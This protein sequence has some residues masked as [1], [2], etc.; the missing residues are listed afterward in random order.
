MI[1]GIAGKEKW[2]KLFNVICLQMF[3]ACS[4]NGN[5]LIGLR[6]CSSLPVAAGDNG[7]A[8][9]L[10]DAGIG[11]KCPTPPWFQLKSGKAIPKST[12]AASL[13]GA[14]VVAGGVVVA[15]AAD[16]GVIAAPSGAGCGGVVGAITAPSEG[17]TDGGVFGTVA[18]HEAGMLNDAAARLLLALSGMGNALMGG[19]CLPARTG[20]AFGGLI[21]GGP[22][23]N[24]IGTAACAA[25]SACAADAA[26]ATPSE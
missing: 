24:D 17:A 14:V 1:R 9:S 25:A 20:G 19:A 12:A 23:I 7:A 10:L 3:K 4:W 18:T 2:P 5:Q 13:A 8:E 11:N 15:G 21:A 16:C 26:A 6:N 22:A